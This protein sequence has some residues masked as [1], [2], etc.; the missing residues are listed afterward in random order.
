MPRAA[1]LV[2]R[3]FGEPLLLG[4]ARVVSEALSEVWRREPAL[5]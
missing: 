2:G 1:Q 3:P 5:A 4:A